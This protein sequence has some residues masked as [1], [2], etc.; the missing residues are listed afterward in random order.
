[1]TKAEVE[2]AKLL[3]KHEKEVI[4]LVKDNY[5]LAIKEIKE[6]IAVLSVRDNIQSKIYQKQYQ[7]EL[8]KILTDILERLNQ[9]DY[10]CIEDYLNDVAKD[11]FYGA[12]YSLHQQSIPV[13]VMI[14]ERVIAKIIATP[15][16]GIKLSKRLYKNMDTLKK[17]LK[18]EISRGFASGKSYQE[19]AVGVSRQTDIDYRKALR[20]ARTEGARVNNESSF[21]AMRRVKELGIDIV[22]QW[23]STLD[24]KTRPHHRQLDGQIREIEEYFQ[25]GGRKTL[26]PCGFGIAS[27]D[28]NCR[29]VALMRVRSELN[30]DYTKWDGENNKLVHLKATQNYQNWKEIYLYD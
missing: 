5:A 20:I 22:K 10:Q 7:Q 13:M 17:V 15:S 14:N 26:Y 9:K 28:I 21:E 3:L 23:D 1:M 27:E 24:K 6:K 30:E 4:Q 19:M 16:D 8:E 29:C 12:V 25:I 2:I 11:S 18:E